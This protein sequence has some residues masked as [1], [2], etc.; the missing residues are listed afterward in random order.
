MV[1]CTLLGSLKYVIGPYVLSKIHV[2]TCM[3]SAEITQHLSGAVTIMDMF[4]FLHCIHCTYEL[5]VS[6][7]GHDI[8]VHVCASLFVQVAM[9]LFT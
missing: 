3:K 8:H 6:Q 4:V 2:Y 7:A 1:M 5:F 9:F